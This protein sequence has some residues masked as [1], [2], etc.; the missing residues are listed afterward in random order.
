MNVKERHA[1]G[2]LLGM[3]IVLLLACNLPA[4]PPTT[5]QV[6][7]NNFPET[8]V[9]GIITDTMPAQTLSP[10]NITIK[11]QT[12][13]ITSTSTPTTTLTPKLPPMP[14]FDPV[15]NFGGGGGG[16]GECNYPNQPNNINIDFNYFLQ[17]LH[18]CIMMYGFNFN[19]P[20]RLAINQLDGSVNW[21]SRDLS[22]DFDN[23][24]I[25][26]DGYPGTHGSISWTSDGTMFV[27]IDIWWPGI[28][29]RGTWRIR[30]IQEKFNATGVFP[31][32]ETHST[33]R[34]LPR[35]ADNEVIPGSQR[36]S[37]GRVNANGWNYPPNTPVYILLYQDVTPPLGK[38]TYKLIQKQ[39]VVSNAKGNIAVEL[40]AP[41]DNGFYALYGITDPHATL[42]ETVQG[43][44]PENVPCNFFGVGG[45]SKYV[46]NPTSFSV[47]PTR[48]IGI[49]TSTQWKASANSCP[50]APAQRMIINQRG[51][52]CTREDAVKLRSVP[53]RSG[54]E[55]MQLAPGTSFAVI[56]GPSCADNWSWWNVRL[57]NGTTGWV[58]E[59]GDQTDPYF[60]C[61]LK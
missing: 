11:T 42:G 1:R 43:D 53:R 61:P 49:A 19:Q 56:G 25:R 8:Q 4:N 5:P 30:A 39:V 28:F 45:T 15:I 17:A 13:T 52:V 21:N 24:A 46:T 50:G 26:W 10:Q 44:C 3:V 55:I 58:S 41:V 37:K 27:D 48:S 31:V 33:I 14:D 20:F 40:S 36:V 22:F 47:N 60:I 29:S 18:M 6:A 54:G 57:D 38:Y 2:G 51:F 16:I 23:K 32:E 59:G 12:P 34:V 7:T 9:S 35:G